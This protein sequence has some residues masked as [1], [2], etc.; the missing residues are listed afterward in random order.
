MQSIIYST[1]SQKGQ[2]KARERVSLR[3][4]VVSEVFLGLNHPTEDTDNA[5]VCD[6]YASQP[7]SR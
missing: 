5:R 7:V 4:H 3:R 6:R 1:I 2:P